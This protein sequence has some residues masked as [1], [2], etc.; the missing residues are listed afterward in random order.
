MDLSVGCQTYTWEMLGPAWR[1]G[2]DDLLAAIAAAGYTGIEITDTMIGHYARDPAAFAVA[3]AAHG[4]ELVAFNF[5]SETGFTRGEAVAA[6]LEMATRWIAFTAHF[7]EAIASIGSPTV[8]SGGARADKFPVAADIC[9]HIA[10]IGRAYG[11]EV[12]VHPSSHQGTLL[13]DRTDYE[14]FVALLEPAVGW[15]P[16]TGHLL[17]GGHRMLDALAAWRDRIRYLHLKDVDAGGRWAMLGTGVCDTPAVLGVVARAP[18]FTGWIVLEEE[19]DAAAA[20]PATA[21]RANRI[22]MRTY[23]V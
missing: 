18:R 15:V 21:V 22:T 1:G 19:S 4:L 12:A 10:G 3:L 16:D 13:L 8:T 17:R 14:R 20:D 6:D 5:A 11:V 9:N 7:P 2:P 23:G